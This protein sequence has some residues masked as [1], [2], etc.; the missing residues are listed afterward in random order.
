MTTYYSMT[1]YCIRF[2]CREITPTNS[3]VFRIA[4]WNAE[5]KEF[6]CLH[7]MLYLCIPNFAVFGQMCDVYH[8]RYLFL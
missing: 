3:V 7:C 6:A 5:Q 1:I 2:L 4:T 8:G